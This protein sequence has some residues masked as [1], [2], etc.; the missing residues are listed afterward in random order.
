MQPE[1]SHGA[2]G[3]GIFSGADSVPNPSRPKGSPFD[4]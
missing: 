1:S 3:V 4:E 2:R